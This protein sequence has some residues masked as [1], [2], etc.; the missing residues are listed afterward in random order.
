MKRKHIFSICALSLA[1]LTHIATSQPVPDGFEEEIQEQTLQGLINGVDWIFG[2]GVAIYDASDDEYLLRLYAEQ[3]E[4]P[5]TLQT[6]VNK[7]LTTMPNQVGPYS[8]SLGG[9]TVTFVENRD[10]DSPMNF[11]AIQGEVNVTAIGEGT[12]EAGMAVLA[13]DNTW[14]NGE[15]TVQIC[16]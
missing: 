3:V 7:I 8:L 11:I 16:E 12:L 13:N 15:F 14:V 5:C 9:S 4:D 2:S 10:D 6:S 1:A